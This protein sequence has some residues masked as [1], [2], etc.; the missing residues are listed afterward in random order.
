MI[1]A[2]NMILLFIANPP[3]S[4]KDPGLLVTGFGSLRLMLSDHE[5][6]LRERERESWVKGK[7]AF[8]VIVLV[9]VASVLENRKR[10]GLSG[11]RNLKT[12]MLTIYLIDAFTLSC[13]IDT[14]LCFQL[15][16]SK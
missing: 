10:D 15:L 8:V 16:R 1:M 7:E 4:E 5:W 6:E 14:F 11:H 13:L 9:M 12:P 2:V 3:G